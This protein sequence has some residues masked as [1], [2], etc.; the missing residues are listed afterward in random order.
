MPHNGRENLIIN[1]KKNHKRERHIWGIVLF[2]GGSLLTFCLLTGGIYFWFNNSIGYNGITAQH[3][4]KIIQ[5]S[6]QVKSN[7]PVDDV[8]IADAFDEVTDAE[9]QQEEIFEFRLDIDTDVL[10]INTPVIEGADLE[11]LAHGVGH[12]KTT[13]RPGFNGNTVIYGH[14]WYPGDNPY[15]HI[16]ND[17]DKLQQGDQVFLFYNGS[18]F[19]YEIIESKIIDADNIEILKQTKE[20][21]LTLYTCTPRYTSEKRLVYIA[22]LIGWSEEK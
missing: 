15:Y 20:P 12:H 11:S 13:A 6:K 1:L 8:V 9:E 2:F 7:G 3:E 16:F 17:L 19:T 18:K 4:K 21:Q 22:K 10:K 5:V 14:R